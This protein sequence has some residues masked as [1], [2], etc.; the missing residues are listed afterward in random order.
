MEV[1]TLDSL[2]TPLKNKK[3]LF[4]D[5][6]SGIFIELNDVVLVETSSKT[7]ICLGG[8]SQNA[9][10]DEHFDASNS[11][12]EE[13]RTAGE[14]FDSERSSSDNPERSLS[15]IDSSN[16]VPSHLHQAEILQNMIQS[17]ENLFPGLSFTMVTTGK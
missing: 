16:A 5:I 10:S 15:D 13:L 1:E 17:V 12:N 9:G 2:E 8:T 14:I 7:L 6:K 3:M 4:D 11:N